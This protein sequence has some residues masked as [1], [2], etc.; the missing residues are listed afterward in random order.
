M[1]EKITNNLTDM[2]LDIEFYKS[3]KDIIRLITRLDNIINNHKNDLI[4][5]IL[6]EILIKIENNNL[7]ID[8]LENIDKTIYGFLL[9]NKKIYLTKKNIEG[10]TIY[11]Y[12]NYYSLYIK[13]KKMKIT[14]Y[15]ENNF[16]NKKIISINI[17]GVK[18]N[19]IN[20]INDIDI[21]NSKNI[22]IDIEK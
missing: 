15:L 20:N 19:N 8:E 14:E 3:K 1:K 13:D 7:N 9:R 12:E 17:D 4:L 10:L 6:K 11:E 22:K 5:E 16:K 2:I 21:I 18:W